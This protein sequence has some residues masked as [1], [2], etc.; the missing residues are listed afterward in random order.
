MHLVKEG[1]HQFK[2]DY[3]ALNKSEEVPTLLLDGHVLTQSVA[4]CELLNEKYSSPDTSLLPHGNTDT[5]RL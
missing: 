1:G 4:I 3:K 2:S 5:L